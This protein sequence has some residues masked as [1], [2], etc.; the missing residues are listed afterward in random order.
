MNRLILQYLLVGAASSVGG[1]LRLFVATMIPNARFPYATMLI[2]IT[3]SMFLGWFLTYASSR[4]GISDLTRIAI[5]TGFVGAYTTFSTYMFEYDKMVQD[6]SDLKATMYL[7]GTLALGLIAV[8][9]GV[10]LAQ[11]GK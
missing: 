8:R 5:A 2:N 7:I 3:G 9:A 10:M 6:G 4:M 1:M 11:V